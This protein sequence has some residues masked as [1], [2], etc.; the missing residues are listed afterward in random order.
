MLDKVLEESCRFLAAA[1]N[2]VYQI[3]GR[4]W[5]TPTGEQLLQEY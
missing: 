3:D 2:G 5:F 4:G 1:T